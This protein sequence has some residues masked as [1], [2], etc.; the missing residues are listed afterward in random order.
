MLRKALLTTALVALVSVPSVAQAQNKTVTLIQ[1]NNGTMGFYGLHAARL[2]GYFEEEGINVKLLSGDTSVPYAAFLTN[3]DVDLAMLDGSE[4]FQARNANIGAVTVYTVHNRAPEG[5][6]VAKDSPLQSVTELKGKTIGL[7]SDRDLAVVKVAMAHAG[8]NADG[9]NTVVVG[10]SG[11]TLANVFLKGTA[12]AFAGS[13]NDVAALLARGIELRDIMPESAKNS[14][15]NTYS[16]LGSRMAELKE[17]LCG[18]FRAYSKGVHVGLE[19]MEAVAALSRKGVPHEWE[20]AAY[21]YRY[22]DT[23]KGL[24]VPP[25]PMKIGEVNVAAWQGV[26]KDMVMIGAVEKEGSLDAIL[27]NDFMDCANDFDR[28]EVAAEVKAWMADPA[29]AEFTKKPASQ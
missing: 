15:A 5:I 9:V 14:P 27:S 13:G 19:D 4:T 2:L 8:T 22:L 29:N 11:P 25:N 24:Q 18:F 7:A 12:A 3:G 20:S 1:P 17:P 23:V 26:Q 10:D 21:G 16:M 6:F 28:A